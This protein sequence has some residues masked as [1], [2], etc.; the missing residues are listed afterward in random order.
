LGSLCCKSEPTKRQNQ[1]V[2]VSEAGTAAG[3]TFLSGTATCSSLP[4]TSAFCTLCGKSCR[5]QASLRS[6]GATQLWCGGSERSVWVLNRLGSSVTE[7]SCRSRFRGWAS[8]RCRVFMKCATKRICAHG[9]R[10]YG[11]KVELFFTGSQSSDQY[12]PN[13]YRGWGSGDPTTRHK[14]SPEHQN[15]APK[16]TPVE[17]PASEKG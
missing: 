4:R 16:S 8:P 3:G 2:G 10:V 9:R 12:Q 11:N 17:N 13:T 1:L 15:R 14:V 5:V 6:S 7:V